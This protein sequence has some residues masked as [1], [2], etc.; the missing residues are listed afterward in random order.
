MRSRPHLPNDV[1]PHARAVVSA[2]AAEDLQQAAVL[3]TACTKKFTTTQRTTEEIEHYTEW[4]RET[5]AAARRCREHLA[6]RLTS[7]NAS[8][9]GRT[10]FENTWSVDA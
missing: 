2:I 9:Y 7:I 1:I 10:T 8:P 5:R 4:L 6:L 3:L